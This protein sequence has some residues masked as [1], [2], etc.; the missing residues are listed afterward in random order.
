[1]SWTALLTQGTCVRTYT[2]IVATFAAHCHAVA[3]G[4]PLH[5]RM[6]SVLLTRCIV[7]VRDPE[8]SGEPCVA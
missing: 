5:K 6:Q 4:R 8:H 2:H 1:M 7:V 3:H